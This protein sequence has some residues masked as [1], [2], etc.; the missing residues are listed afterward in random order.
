MPITIILDVDPMLPLLIQ[1]HMG[2]L[3]DR[4]DVH[5]LHIVSFGP[6]R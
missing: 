2:E 4:I 6:T 3:F 1:L 5:W